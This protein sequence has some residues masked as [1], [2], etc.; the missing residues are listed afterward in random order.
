M[1]RL[2]NAYLGVA[3]VAMWPDVLKEMCAARD[4]NVLE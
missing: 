3:S 1:L 4:I 2:R